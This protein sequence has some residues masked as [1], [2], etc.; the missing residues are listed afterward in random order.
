MNREAHATHDRLPGT[1]TTGFGG[2]LDVR[3]MQNNGSSQLLRYPDY[4]VTGSVELRWYVLEQ[5]GFGLR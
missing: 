3:G 5:F 2:D 1:E 4:V